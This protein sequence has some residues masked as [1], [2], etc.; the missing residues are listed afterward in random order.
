MV[1]EVVNIMQ[2]DTIGVNGVFFKLSGTERSTE[3]STPLSFY[4]VHSFWLS[5]INRSPIERVGGRGGG[6][7]LLALRSRFSSSMLRQLQN[8]LGFMMLFQ[9]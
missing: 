2:Y 9:S 7:R 1:A 6:V 5:Y 8:F 4:W 3:E